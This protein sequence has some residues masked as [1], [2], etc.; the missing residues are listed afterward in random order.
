MIL[1]FQRRI[2]PEQNEFIGGRVTV[3]GIEIRLV[4][5]IDTDAGVVKTYDVFG[6]GK[7]HCRCAGD[8]IS[9]T[10]TGEVELFRRDGAKYLGDSN[11]R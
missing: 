2:K 4:W 6:D 1:D 9:R 7:P 11:G 5:Y 3:D 8:L 10:I